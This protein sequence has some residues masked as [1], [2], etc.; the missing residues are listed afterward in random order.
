MGTIVLSSP[1]T[2]QLFHLKVSSSL[3][4]IS[5]NIHYLPFSTSATL[6]YKVI[7]YKYLP[8]L[9]LVF[10]I[11]IHLWLAI[12]P[13]ITREQYK[14]FTAHT[15]TLV[16]V[17]ADNSDE[18][19]LILS[20]AVHMYI[21]ELPLAGSTDVP[22]GWG[23]FIPVLRVPWQSRW[24]RKGNE[25][26]INL[27]TLSQYFVNL[28]CTNWWSLSHVPLSRIFYYSPLTADAYSLP[29]QIHL[30][31]PCHPHCPQVIPIKCLETLQFL[32]HPQCNGI[33]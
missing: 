32:C 22:A 3:T 4:N 12:L 15:C 21:D 31:A 11:S 13:S 27:A 30:Y 14:H 10:S 28:N 23:W 6:K 29:L 1:L 19:S 25:P 16:L 33:K 26:C 2:A 7:L 9:K 5:V 18:R 24:L 8:F 17:M 20:H